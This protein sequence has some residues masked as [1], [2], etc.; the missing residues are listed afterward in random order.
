MTA[1]L[2]I[3]G[4]KNGTG[5]Q[6]D[7]AAEVG[8]LSAI[9]RCILTFQQAGVERVVVCG[10]EEERVEKLAPHMNVTFLRCPGGGEMLNS[11]KTGLSFLQD[12]CRA[13][14]IANTNVPLFSAGTVCTL[15]QAEGPV[16][17]PVCRGRGGHPIRLAAELIPQILSYCG[18]GGLAGAIRASGAERV[19][20]EVEDE[21]TLANTRDGAACESLLSSREE[22]LRP[23][24]RFQLVRDQAFYGPGAHQLLQLIEETGSLL[25]ACRCMGISYSKGRKMISNL[26]RNMGCP[27]LESTRGGREGGASTVTDAGKELIRSYTAFCKEARE[28]LTQLF[29]KYFSCDGG[30]GAAE[31]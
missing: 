20:L 30:G 22:E 15:L 5:R 2:I 6:L 27:I 19:A 11:V 14:L 3:A 7:P 21:G 24:F 10:D 12:K 9:K 4:G 31:S 8:S 13:V 25:E 28:Y 23:A 16:C 17:V 18:E 29:P 26:E 1:A